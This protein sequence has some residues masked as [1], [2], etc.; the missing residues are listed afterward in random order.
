MKCPYD[1]K[2]AEQIDLLGYF[3]RCP[4]C[5]ETVVGGRPHPAFQES[6]SGANED[7]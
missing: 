7:P 1:P 6:A 4:Q 2:S 5:G 3:Y